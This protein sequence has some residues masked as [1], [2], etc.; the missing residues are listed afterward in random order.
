MKEKNETAPGK[1]PKF[2]S[3]ATQKGGVGKST[4]TAIVASLLHYR[5]DRNV[6]VVDVDYPQHSLTKIREDELTAVKK[7]KRL[8]NIVHNQISRLNKGSYPILSCSP[9]DA[10]NKLDEFDLSD[11]DFVLFDMPGTIN[12]PGLVDL[13]ANINYIFIPLVAD[14]IVMRAALTYA[15][16]IRQAFILRE[17]CVKEVRCFWTRVDGRDRDNP[18]YDHYAAIIEKECEVKLMDTSIP[19]SVRFN[20]EITSS[21]VVRSTLI[22]PTYATASSLHLSSFTFELLSI[23]Q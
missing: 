1:R 19:N 11:I 22:P 18:F 5:Y 16:A 15:L 2:V 3:I 10:L 14:H 20:K 23:C 21:E 8:E 17:S 13:L 7:D 6:I 4:L 12:Q 9:D